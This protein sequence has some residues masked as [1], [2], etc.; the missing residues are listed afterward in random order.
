M[1]NFKK[2]CQAERQFVRPKE[3]LWE[4][5]SVK[6]KQ[7]LSSQKEVCQAERESF[8]PKESLSS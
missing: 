6:L 5:K 4:Q 2:V 3:S 1:S 8:R 7:G